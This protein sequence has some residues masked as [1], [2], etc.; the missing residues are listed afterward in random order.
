MSP[1]QSSHDDGQS[2]TPHNE[3]DYIDGGDE[4][5]ASEAETCQSI[6]PAHVEYEKIL[7]QLEAECRNHIKCEQ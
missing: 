6:P 2:E 3:D 7:Q 1:E 4:G 5:G